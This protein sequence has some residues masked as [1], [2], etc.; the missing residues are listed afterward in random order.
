MVWEYRPVH[1]ESHR[2][3]PSGGPPDSAS[4]EKRKKELPSFDEFESELTPDLALIHDLLRPSFLFRA[5]ELIKKIP[6]M[7]EEREHLKKHV[8]E[9]RASIAQHK[10]IA[11]QIRKAIKAIELAQKAA[12][13][14]DP[15]LLK[16]LD[17]IAAQQLLVQAEA[18][19]S[20]VIDEMFPGFIHPTLRKSDEK[21]TQ[22]NLPSHSSKAFPGFGFARIDYWLIEEL[23]KCLDTA[24]TTKGKVGRVGR[25]KI[26]MR[27]FEVA[28]SKTHSL[29]QIKNARIRMARQRRNEKKNASK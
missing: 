14:E 19:L 17:V 18:D 29:D 22:V 3:G 13:E 2:T 4:L 6:R 8:P 15:D 1:Q 12:R 25:D 11:T 7:E 24:L 26:I 16:S 27:V 5:F 10:K 9:I 20:W 23:D 21:P 28:F